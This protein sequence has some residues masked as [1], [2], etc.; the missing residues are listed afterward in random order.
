[1]GVSSLAPEIYHSN[2]KKK[3]APKE[4][5][6]SKGLMWK[7]LIMWI[8]FLPKFCN[9]ILTEKAP[10]S[11]LFKSFSCIFLIQNYWFKKRTIVDNV[12]N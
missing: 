6:P 11:G 2:S 10:V 5:Q 1:M 3:S 12:D 8:T 9:I 4:V 7:V